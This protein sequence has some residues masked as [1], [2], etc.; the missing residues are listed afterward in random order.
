MEGIQPPQSEQ[1]TLAKLTSQYA[2]VRSQMIAAVDWRATHPTPPP[3]PE[4]LFDDR[5]EPAKQF[6]RVRE[7]TT[8]SNLDHV[9]EAI[10]KVTG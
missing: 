3:E 7:Y 1:T 2:W 4:R 5:G 10:A 6:F 9:T 8:D